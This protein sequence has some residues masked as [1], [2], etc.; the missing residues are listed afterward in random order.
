[1]NLTFC[2]IITADYIHYALA[3]NHSLLKFNKEAL[4]KIFVSDEYCDFCDVKEEFPNIEFYYSSDLCK[5]GVSKKIYDKYTNVNMSYFRWSMK[6]VFIKELLK[7]YDQV[8][9]LDADLFFYS[10][11]DFL[12]T[13]L[14]QHGVLLTPH[15]RA[16]DPHQDQS[17]FAIL[18]TS[19]F[20][21]AGFVG[22]SSLGFSAM[23]WWEG[24]CEYECVLKPEKG[25]FGDQAYLDLF[26]VLFDKVKVLKHKGCNVANW[27]QLECKREV[28][29]DEEV[30][31]N[32][33]WDIVF[34]HFTKSTINGILS[35]QDAHL[36]P[37]LEI[38]FEKLDQFKA[39]I[40]EHLIND[41]SKHDSYSTVID[42]EKNKIQ[43]QSEFIRMPNIPSNIDKFGLRRAIQQSLEK[44]MPEMEGVLL[45]VGCG[46]KPYKGLIT[47]EASKVDKYIGLDFKDNPIHNNNPDIVWEN[48][49]IPL[50]DKSIDSVICTEVLEHC[51]HP[52]MV[53]KEISR[54]LKLGGTLFFT[55]PFLWPLHEVPF[56]EYR[57][58]PFSLERHLANSGFSNIKISALGGWDASLAQMI[59]LWVRRRK[60]NRWIRSL[61]SYIAWPVVFFLLK[62]DKKKTVKFS[63]GSMITGLSGTAT[64]QH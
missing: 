34:I 57:Y 4:L 8:F 37:H 51:P 21:N 63:E 28:S 26:P 62:I 43:G 27:N 19:G 46:N 49:Q 3:L 39:W 61:L 50:L 54:V 15:W 38:Y 24:V 56:D 1:M 45:D 12:S 29:V 11:Y 14:N 47:S 18:Q 36:K 33:T 41:K 55:V 6:P 23:N 10:S 42:L 30:K 58:T 22:V 2:T 16:S 48:G 17:N 32:G 53:L 40:P 35:G 20:F 52:E 5:E 59:G 7:S 25:L 44:H 31:I 64:R 13:E 60:M 9:F